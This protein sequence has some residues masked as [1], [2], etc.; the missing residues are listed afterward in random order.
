MKK[1]VKINRLKEEA[2]RVKRYRKWN[3][4]KAEI[5]IKKFEEIANRNKQMEGIDD[6]KW[7]AIGIGK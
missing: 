7:E 4:R 1:E 5:K 6:N 3:Y 2:K